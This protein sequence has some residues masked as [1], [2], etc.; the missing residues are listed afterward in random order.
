MV[1]PF[2]PPP[3]S[4]RRRREMTEFQDPI[5]QLEYWEA[6]I[7]KLKESFKEKKDDKKPPSAIEQLYMFLA[8]ISVMI[9][10]GYPLGTLFIKVVEGLYK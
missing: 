10:V 3:R 7:K 5:A 2:G 4:R 8:Q 6:S 9:V 1:P